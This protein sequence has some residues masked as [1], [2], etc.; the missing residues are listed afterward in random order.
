[1]AARSAGGLS[2]LAIAALACAHA[3]TA[4]T[5]T[6]DQVVAELRRPNKKVLTFVGYSGTGYED[7]AAMLAAAEAILREHEPTETIVNAG[8]TPDGIGAVYELAKRLRFETTGIVSVQAR[9]DGVAPSPYVDR[10]FYV[11]DETWGGRLDGSDQLSPTSTAMVES[12]DELVG[13]GGG[14]IARD[15]L[16]AAREAG[17]TVRFVPADTNHEKAR[18]AAAK[19]GKPAPPDFRGAAATAF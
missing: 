1:M 10:V 7:P 13:I 17:K 9:N 12:S 19:K 15:E 8:A 3:V 18:A 4:T 6:P 14:E 16:V 11:E 5:H 2:A